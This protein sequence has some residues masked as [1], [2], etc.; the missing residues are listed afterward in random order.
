MPHTRGLRRRFVASLDHPL[1]SASSARGLPDA[2][3]QPDQRLLGPDALLLVRRRD[4]L[5]VQW[6]HGRL[7]IPHLSADYATT[8]AVREP[9]HRLPHGD[10]ASW[11]S[12]QHA[13]RVVR[14]RL[15]LDHHLYRRS[16]AVGRGHVSDVRR[17][18]YADRDAGR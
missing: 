18:R 15:H 1:R 5:L 17:A 14:P 4:A 6:L 9:R 16:V 11:L 12:V 8:M 13:W 10:A 7:G 2:R 3:A